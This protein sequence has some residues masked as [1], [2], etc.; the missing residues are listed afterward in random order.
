M[1]NSTYKGRQR[2]IFSYIGGPCLSIKKN[3]ELDPTLSPAMRL[4]I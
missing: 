2:E 1:L 4:L 3:V